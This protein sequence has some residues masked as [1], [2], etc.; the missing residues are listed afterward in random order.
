MKNGWQFKTLGELC[1]FRP[2]KA[3][4]RN[5]LS[6]TDQV[7]FFGMEDLGIDQKYP[8]SERIR[9]LGDVA[10]SYTYFAEGDLLL[11]KITPCFQNGKLGIA[12][13]LKNGVGFGSSEFIVI[14]PAPELDREYLYYFLSREGFRAEGVS[15]MGGSVGQQRVPNSFIQGQ[16]IPV[17]P[18]AEQRRIV[19]ILDEAFEG[20][21]TAK[22][23]AE[24]N[25]QSARALFESHLHAVFTQRGE[26]WVDVRLGDIAKTQYGLSQAMNS[27]GIG[28]K[29]FRMGE[30]QGG[31]LLDTGQMKFV[32]IG[33][34]EFSKYRLDPGDVLFNRTNSFELV[35]K[36]GIFDLPGEYCF[37][38]YLIRL[39]LPR[40]TMMPSFLNYF[41]N[42]A[43]F[44]TSVKAKASKSINQANINAT[45]LSNENIR[46][47]QSLEDQKAIVNRLD[48]LREH[49]QRLESLY[50]RKL[51]A[52][53][54]LK[55]SL[56][57]RAFSGN[58]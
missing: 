46:Y 37:A 25:L 39:T 15:R 35:G 49:T 24:K 29:I 21:A 18:L 42:T 23:N 53:D 16:Q 22:A 8:C 33:R 48:S 47:P 32:D 11:A 52:L 9:S 1:E 41:M 20:I 4:A 38:S 12:R 50:Q 54:E 6:A 58:L 45:I 19:G 28:F 43:H 13:D 36:T 44:Q 10:G 57:H 26:G 56:L 14:R 7:S 5:R 3:E 55:Q 51:A 2:K 34:A 17:L 40:N 30:V 27:E 31:R